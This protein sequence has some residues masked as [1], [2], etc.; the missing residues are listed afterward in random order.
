MMKTNPGGQLAP[1]EVVGRDPLIAKL[2]KVLARQSLV[3][4]AERRIGKT[5]IVKKMAAQPQDGVRV[6]W[7]DVEGFRTPFEFADCV[8]QD[9]RAEL[10]RKDRLMNRVREL[11][12]QIGGVEFQ[13]I[14]LPQK[15]TPHWK[16]L[17]IKTLEDL[18]EHQEGL[19][20][21]CWDELPMMLDKV[22]RDLGET[23]AME[24]L[25][26]LRSIRQTLPQV[27][28]IFTGSIGLHHVLSQMR[29]AGYANDPTNDMFKQEVLPLDW[30]DACQLAEQLLHGERIWV[31]DS[32]ELARAIAK[33]VDCFP[34]YIHHVVDAMKWID[35][36]KSLALVEEVILTGLCDDGNRW[37][38]AHYHDRI[39]TYY[40]ETDQTLTLAIL[41]E[42]AQTDLPL[43]FPELCNRLGMQMAVPEPE[44]VRK[45]LTLLRRDHYLIQ[46]P[47]GLYRFKFGLIQ[48]YWRL[49]RGL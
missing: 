12:E 31:E 26:T 35:K 1:N 2:W 45:L 13:G 19:F 21:F 49:Y 46:Q 33:A 7:R 43:S 20:V 24:V 41:D 39:S 11:M 8:F 27:R 14:K 16:A 44:E 5:S 37:D 9:V 29:E 23:E 15:V 3:L 40:A 30:V 28:M 10:S 42:L 25:D 6:F 22:K 48:R 4:T 32:R 34:Y 47:D 18:A 38:M 36:P 17:L